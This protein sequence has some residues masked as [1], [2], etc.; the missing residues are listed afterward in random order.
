MK[1]GKMFFVLSILVLLIAA[2]C[3]FTT[4]TTN[5]F[6]KVK[7]GMTLE[8][9]SEAMGEPKS[10]TRIEI[11]HYEEDDSTIEISIQDERVVYANATKVK[12]TKK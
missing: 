12:T 4:T 1:T 11:W 10:I 5:T 8:E 3:S 6:S 2:S 7:P 9:V